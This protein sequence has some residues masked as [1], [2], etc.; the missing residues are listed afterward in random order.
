M[1]REEINKY[2]F[3]GALALKYRL[4]LVNVCRLAMFFKIIAKPGTIYDNL[5]YSVCGHKSVNESDEMPFRYLF[6]SETINETTDDRRVLYNNALEF[7]NTYKVVPRSLKDITADIE[8]ATKEQD[9]E[10]LI[11][12]KNEQRAHYTL[13]SEEIEYNALKKSIK[14]AKD[15]GE[16]FMYSDNDILIIARY[17]LK[18]ALSEMSIV[19]DLGIS[20]SNY[21]IREKRIADQKFL[22]KLIKL[23]N[24]YEDLLYSNISNGIVG[25]R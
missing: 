21:T 19:K 24:F 11:I 14:K 12:L 6:N 13:Y 3:L 2:R 17:R 5:I 20:M 7:I 4:S 8:N 15:S 18:Y 25:K 23:N 16:K 10:K 1:S 22:S 9:E